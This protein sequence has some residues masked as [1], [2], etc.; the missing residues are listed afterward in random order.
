MLE[1]NTLE[2]IRALALHRSP[3]E[4]LA[5]IRAIIESEPVELEAVPAQTASRA[6]WRERLTAEAAYWH[7]RPAEERRPFAGHYV[8][9]HNQ[10]VIDHDADLRVLYLRMRERFPR[11]PVLLTPADATGPRELTIR[12]PRLEPMLP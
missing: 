11:V 5:L 10:T 9:V 4:R 7:A 3:A 6:E 1:S 12:S 8:A 2:M